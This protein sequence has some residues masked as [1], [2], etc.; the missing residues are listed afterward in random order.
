MIHAYSESYLADAKSCLGELFDYAVNDCNLEIDWV[1]TLFV[2]SGYAAKFEV[3]N[4]GILSG[5][6]GIELAHKVLQAVHCEDEIREATFPEDRSPEYWAGWALAE[7]QWSSARN[8]KDIFAR[9][10]M[11]E[12]VRMYRVYH[13]MDISQ[14]LEAMEHRYTAVVCDTKL[15]KIR[16]SKGISQTELSVRSGVKLRSI[17]MYEQRGNDID[18][19]QAQTVYKLARALGCGVEDL[20]EEPM[21]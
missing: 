16:E 8:F 3:G 15:K 4:P 12:I 18:K 11:S 21:M 7:Y 1:S 5:L 10:P 14:F 17:Q 20:L 6:S 13:E 9:I 19:A 2:Q